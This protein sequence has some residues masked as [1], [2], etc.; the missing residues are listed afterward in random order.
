MV[1]SEQNLY[2]YALMVVPIQ[3]GFST[4]PSLG[5]ARALAPLESS[6]E[7]YPVE[8]KQVL[9]STFSLFPA[10]CWIPPWEKLG[11]QDW[12]LIEDQSS[13][14]VDSKLGLEHLV[15][16]DDLGLETDFYACL[17]LCSFAHACE[18]RSPQAGTSEIVITTHTRPCGIGR[19]NGMPWGRLIPIVGMLTTT[20]H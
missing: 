7:P 6:F 8:I 2:R 20:G 16:H 10:S 1:V 9:I 17:P 12:G 5:F 13:T 19:R 15:R 14:L 4:N 3:I 18:G 11:F